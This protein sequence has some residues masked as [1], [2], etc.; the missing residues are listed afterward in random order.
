MYQLG[1]WTDLEQRA[2]AFDIEAGY[3]L[4][5]LPL[6]PWVRGGYFWSSGD[7]DPNDR[8]HRT[9][10]A[11]LPTAR[12]YANFAFYNEMNIRDGF[13][14]LLL[15]PT[16]ST[17]VRIDYHNLSLSESKDL[18]YAGS[19]AQNRSLSFGYVGRASN[20]ARTLA[21]VIEAGVTYDINQYF[22]W[23]AY[24]AHAFGGGVIQRFFHGRDH[25]DY[26]LLEFNA[27]F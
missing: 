11:V 27:T 3:Q 22:S 24:Y 12:I 13:A 6:V 4:T 16:S 8:T 21:E 20:G 7:A 18:F 23:N 10:F 19:G 26:G 2:G 25:A 1:D 15:S 14:Q 5:T 9:F 17:R